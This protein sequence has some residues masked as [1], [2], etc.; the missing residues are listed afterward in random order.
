MISIA[1]ILFSADFLVF[2]EI[3][4]ISVSGFVDMR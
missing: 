3:F 4:A 1:V 2:H